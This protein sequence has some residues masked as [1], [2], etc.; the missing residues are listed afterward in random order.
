MKIENSEPN[1]LEP[2]ENHSIFTAS[3]SSISSLYSIMNFFSLIWFDRKF[4]HPSLIWPANSAV[5]I[6]GRRPGRQSGRP[7]L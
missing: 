5:Q 7:P 1:Q 6:F 3:V 4:R 2:I